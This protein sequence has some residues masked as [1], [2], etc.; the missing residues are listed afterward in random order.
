MAI[1]A[2]APLSEGEQHRATSLLASQGMAAALPGDVLAHLQ[3]RRRAFKS[4][5][6][7]FVERRS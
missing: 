7:D 6:L 3:K 4:S 2:E 5:G 1:V